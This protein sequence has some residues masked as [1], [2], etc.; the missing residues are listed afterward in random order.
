LSA[1]RRRTPLHEP[2]PSAPPSH[3]VFAHIR[4]LSISRC[5]DAAP[6]ATPWPEA[7]SCRWAEPPC[8]HARRRA[9]LGAHL[10]M[11]EAPLGPPGAIEHGGGHRLAGDLAV[12]EISAVRTPLSCLAARWDL[13]NMGACLSVSC[14]F[15]GYR[16]GVRVAF[17]RSGFEND[18][19]NVFPENVKM[20][21]KII[22]WDLWLQKLWNKFL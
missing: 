9:C 19:E 2:R 8:H 16:S 1:T 7:C 10:T 21:P 17:K 11:L 18:F 5:S 4:T 6:C 13:S 12:G 3:P 14:V 20:I 22:S 15:T